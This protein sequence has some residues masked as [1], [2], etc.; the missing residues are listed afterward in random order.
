[1]N[2]LSIDKL[3]MV[4]KGLTVYLK[5]LLLSGEIPGAPAQPSPELSQEIQETKDFIIDLDGI[6]EKKK[7]L[8]TY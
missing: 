4:K 1:M 7:L 5:A 3:T 2:E 6:I 8:T